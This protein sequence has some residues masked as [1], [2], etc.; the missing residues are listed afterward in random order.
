MTVGAMEVAL[1]TSFQPSL[2]PSVH[3]A[4]KGPTSSLNTHTL[5]PS[6]FPLD[7]SK[8]EQEFQLFNKLL[9]FV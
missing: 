2:K 9:Q 4:E 3:P 6:I 8:T 7:S 5:T 1:A